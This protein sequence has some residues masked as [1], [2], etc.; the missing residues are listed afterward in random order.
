MDVG[1]KL[2]RE[3]VLFDL[4]ASVS[5]ALKKASDTKCVVNIC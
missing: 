3:G 1:C 2:I 5:L 4:L